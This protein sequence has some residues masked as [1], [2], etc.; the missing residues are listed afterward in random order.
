MQLVRM[1]SVYLM[2]PAAVGPGVYAACN[3]NTYQ[4]QKNNNVS[5]EKIAT[6]A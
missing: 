6:G 1:F 5:D 2:L 3:R 4:K